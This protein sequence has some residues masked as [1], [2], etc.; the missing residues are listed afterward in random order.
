MLGKVKVLRPGRLRRSGRFR[1]VDPIGV[2]MKGGSMSRLFTWPA[3]RTLPRRIF[4]KHPQATEARERPAPV[5][6]ISLLKQEKLL[7][8]S[9]RAGEAIGAPVI[10]LLKQGAVACETSRET[11]DGEQS[12]TGAT[13]PA[14]VIRL[15]KQEAI[16]VGYVALAPTPAAAAPAPGS[17][18]PRRN[19]TQLP[20]ARSHARWRSGSA[21]CARRGRQCRAYRGCRRPR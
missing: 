1:V 3:V 15:L 5:P 19:G 18:S 12:A 13:F 10:C 9:Q 21:G 14:P 6:V 16:G 4:V 8:A 20:P 17:R 2:A 7:Q 11:S